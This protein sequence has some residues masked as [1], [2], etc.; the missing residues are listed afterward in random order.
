MPEEIARF[1]VLLEDIQTQVRAIADGHAGLTERMDRMDARLGRLETKVDGLE[2]NAVAMRIEIRALA[3]KVE[4]SALATRLERVETKLEGFAVDT[5]SRLERIETHVGLN[6]PLPLRNAT[7][8]VPPRHP[9]HRKKAT[10]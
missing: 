10:R 2:V 3:T 8:P 1:T 4:V 9:R 6:R 5:R 7:R